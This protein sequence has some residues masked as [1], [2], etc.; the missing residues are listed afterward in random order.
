MDFPVQAALIQSLNG[1]EG[2]SYNAPFT[3]LYEALAN[4]FAYPD[5]NN[6]LVM[7][8]NHDMDRLFMQLK[9]DPALVKM[10]LTYICTIRGIPQLFYGTEINM[11]NTPHHKNDGIIRSDFPGG[12]KG[13]SINAFTG[14]GLTDQQKDMQ[15]YVK[16]LLNWRKQQPVIANGKTMHFAPFDGLYVYFRYDEKKTIMVVMNKNNKETNVNCE[17]FSEILG[18]GSTAKDI[19]TNQ[20]FDLHQGINVKPKTT[21]VLEIIGIK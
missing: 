1:E 6:I 20:L 9:Q 16:Q 7:A 21:T 17:R 11:D 3:K 8:D 5:P 2:E 14:Q 19:M 12:W 15:G 10:A 18:Q 13:D 4:D